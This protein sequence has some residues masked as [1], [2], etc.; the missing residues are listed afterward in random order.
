[1]LRPSF[2]PG[3]WDL[4]RGR[5][6][7]P[8]ISTVAP[9]SS[10]LVPLEDSYQS[11][12]Y[13]QDQIGVTEARGAS[14]SVHGVTIATL[15]RSRDSARAVF[16]NRLAAVPKDL[17]PADSAA[18]Q[19][20]RESSRSLLASDSASSVGETATESCDY[21]PDSLARQLRESPPLR[22]SAELLRQGHRKTSGGR[23]AAQPARNPGTTGTHRRRREAGAA[24]SGAA[25]G[26]AQHQRSG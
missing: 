13:W 12:R 14:E 24:V 21:A 7:L 8:F 19:V 17:T 22:A 23:R 3:D 10:P 11:L 16:Q 4:P 20:I 26:L 1:M 5:D 25:T 9:A 6:R 18:L 15:Q 2:S